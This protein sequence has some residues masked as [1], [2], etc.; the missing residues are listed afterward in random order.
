[1]KKQLIIIGMLVGCVPGI[2]CDGTSSNSSGEALAL[3]TEV[4]VDGT[5]D[6]ALEDELLFEITDGAQEVEVDVVAYDELDAIADALIENGHTPTP[7]T[8]TP[9][10]QVYLKTLGV[11]VLLKFLALREFL[12]NAWETYL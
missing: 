9:N 4:V 12:G 7:G 2:H 5:I 3:L 10:W 8:I 6:D 1:M 11:S